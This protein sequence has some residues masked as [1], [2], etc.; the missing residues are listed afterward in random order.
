VLVLRATL[1]QHIHQFD[2][3]LGDLAVALRRDPRDVQ[4][5][6]TRATVLQVRGEWDAARRDCQALTGLTL[7]LVT[8][9]CTAGVDSLHGRLQSSYAALSG[10]LARHPEA[11]PAIREWV[12][13]QL[14][15]MAERLG[16]AEDARRLYDAAI[17]ADP[18]DPYVIGTYAD[19]FLDHH[20]PERAAELTR[21]HTRNDALLLRYALAHKAMGAA[22]A[23]GLVQE[24]RDRFAASRLRGDRVHLR[25]EARFRLELDGDAESA[26]RLAQENWAVQKEPADAGIFLQ[27]AAA[28]HATD[29]GDAVRNWLSERGYEDARFAV[30]APRRVAVS[31]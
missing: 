2:A 15:E 1:R 28:A 16:R 9:A 8:A 20:Q 23:A 18:Q 21:E 12:L 24:L 6:L 19:F 27:A 25:E 10:V 17:A 5:R 29:A 26:L 14:A 3:A 30:T 22:D 11:P 4:S 31:Q 7:E 13:S